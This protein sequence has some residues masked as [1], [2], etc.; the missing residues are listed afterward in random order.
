MISHPDRQKGG[1]NQD[2][3]RLEGKRRD[4]CVLVKR[5]PLDT[6]KRGP[7]QKEKRQFAAVLDLGERKRPLRGSMLCRR[8]ESSSINGKGGGG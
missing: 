8:R 1:K 5:W 6:T 2:E 7:R 4:R 3:P